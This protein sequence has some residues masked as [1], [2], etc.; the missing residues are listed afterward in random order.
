MIGIIDYG[1]GN[2]RSVKNSLS[3]IGAKYFVSNK[4]AELSQADKIIFPGVGEAKTAMAALNNLELASWLKNI[5]KPFLG[6]CLGMQ[7]LFERTTESSTNCLGI[8]RGTVDLFD[9]KRFQIKVPQ[10]GWNQVAVVK[11]SLFEG[12]KP[13]EYFYFVH[14]Y[15]APIVEQ[16]IGKTDYGINFTSAL[17]NKNFYGVQFHPEKSGK[18]GLQILKNFIELCK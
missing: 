13:N 11:N 1:A 8:I 17:Q 15:Y 6:I 16:T 9:S 14:S 3:K 7:L 10:I 12:V 2:I 18:A 5:D 4:Q